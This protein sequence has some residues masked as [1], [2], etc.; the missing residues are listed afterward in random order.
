MCCFGDGSISDSGPCKA[1]ARKQSRRDIAPL[2]SERSGRDTAPLRFSAPAASAAQSRNF[3]SPSL[4]RF[5]PSQ[6]SVMSASVLVLSASGFAIGTSGFE[7]SASGFAMGASVL[8]M[9]RSGFA[10]SASGFAMSASGF[11]MGASGFAMGASGFAMAGGSELVVPVGGVTASV[12][13]LPDGWRRGSAG[14]GWRVVFW[15]GPAEASAPWV[16]SGG[17]GWLGWLTRWGESASSGHGG[18]P[19]T[20][21]CL[22]SAGFLDLLLDAGAD[23][24]FTTFDRGLGA[25]DAL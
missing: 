3:K 16:S 15:D 18:S 10:M 11:A 17:V 13:L 23:G 14:C 8:A 6:L 12:L 19:K 7:M 21:V 25:G 2:M 22:A 1:S 9:G 4:W 24:I 5:P 20:V